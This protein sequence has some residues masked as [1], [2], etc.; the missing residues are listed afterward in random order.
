MAK[1]LHLYLRPPGV[2][3]KYQN[4]WANSQLVS[5]ETYAAVVRHCSKG[6]PVR[7]HRRKHGTTPAY[8]CRECDVLNVTPLANGGYRVDFH[9]WRPLFIPS[10]KKLQRGWY[11]A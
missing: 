6:A 4:Q 8:I 9:N 1:K 11:L 5:I 10:D 3:N 7:V 2:S